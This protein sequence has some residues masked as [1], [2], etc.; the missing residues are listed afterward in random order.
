MHTALVT[1]THPSHLLFT[2]TEEV[3]QS[4]PFPHI[5][6]DGSLTIRPMFAITR[7]V[8][9]DP[10]LARVTSTLMNEREKNGN[11]PLRYS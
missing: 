1:Q 3:S 11:L 2:V 5:H 6:P 4:F 8:R 9:V 10:G 7:P